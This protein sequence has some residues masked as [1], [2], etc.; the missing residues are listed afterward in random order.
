MYDIDIYM[1]WYIYV[2]SFF[3]FL[4]AS[5]KHASARLQRNRFIILSSYE[6]LDFYSRVE[7]PEMPIF[8]H[9]KSLP[10]QQKLSALLGNEA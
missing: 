4:G 2:Y 1:I 9:E 10:G 3:A 7:C 8:G 6:R 5:I